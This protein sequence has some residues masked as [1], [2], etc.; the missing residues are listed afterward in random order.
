[1]IRIGPAGIPL[2][3]KGRT[4]LDGIKYTQELGLNIM[5]VQFVRG[6][7]IDEEYAEEC[8]EASKEREVPL[9]IHA[10]YYTNLATDSEKTLE[11]TLD[12]IKQAGR[13]AELMHADMV[14]INPGFYTSHSKEET[15]EVVIE[16][17]RK[18]RDWYTRHD[19]PAKLGLKTM[20]KQ[21]TFG[22]LEELV[23]V[24]KR[25]KH[26]VPVLNFSNIHGRTNGSLNEQEDFQAV[27]DAVES[28]KV[29]HYHLQFSGVQ[30]ENG[31]VINTIPIKKSDLHFEPLVEC[32][33][34]N[35][36]DVTIISDSPIVEHDAMYMKIILERALEKREIEMEKIFTPPAEIP[37]EE[38]EDDG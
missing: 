27:F 20:G 24:H 16:N 37:E 1:M 7:T 6:I 14:I 13:M 26:T 17:I 25:V 28:L 2:S 12:K 18:A 8:G 31:N 19:I 15:L 32:I 4:I 23:Q 10:P 5:E 38:Q 9:A 11:A 36:Y 29:D 35:G 22:T 34:D 33:L 3:S 21:K 30:Y